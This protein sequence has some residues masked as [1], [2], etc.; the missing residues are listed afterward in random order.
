MRQLMVALVLLG[1]AVTP[2][3]DAA[4]SEEGLRGQERICCGMARGREEAAEAASG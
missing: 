1:I 2:G 3:T 4:A